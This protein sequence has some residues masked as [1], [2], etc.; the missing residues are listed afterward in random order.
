MCTSTASALYFSGSPPFMEEL[1]KIVKD[2]WKYCR[3]P[4]NEPNYGT[5]EKLLDSFAILQK[6]SIHR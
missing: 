2:S 6:I 1:S 4:Q 5:E 3:N